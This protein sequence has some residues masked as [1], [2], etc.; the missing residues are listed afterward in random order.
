VTDH[1]SA[2]FQ[3]FTFGTLDDLVHSLE[4][5]TEEQLNWRPAAPDTNSL[6]AIVTHVLG[7]A[8]ENVLQTVCGQRIVRSRAGELGAHGTSWEPVR[9]RWNDLRAR[10][11]TALAELPARDLDRERVHPRRGPL[12][13]RDVLLVV[14]RHAAEHW[15]E[16]Q[17]TRSL[18]RARAAGPTPAAGRVSA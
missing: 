1:E 7:N 4:G 10:M 2:S 6:Y 12:T 8:E 5:L 3:R 9:D 13:G 17:L 18:L 11:Q 15:G 16:A 14:A